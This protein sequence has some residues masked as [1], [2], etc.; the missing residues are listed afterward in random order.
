MKPHMFVALL[1]TSVLLI[2][3]PF[4]PH[5]APGTV[6]VSTFPDEKCLGLLSRT[7]S[8]NLAVTLTDCRSAPDWQILADG[9]IG[10]GGRRSPTYCLNVDTASY[11]PKNVSI[12]ECSGSTSVNQVWTW[13]GDGT[14]KLNSKDLCLTTTETG[15]GQLTI[16]G[17]S[18]IT[19]ALKS[20][21][22]GAT[23][24]FNT[25]YQVADQ[26]KPDFEPPYEQAHNTRIAKPYD[27]LKPGLRSEV[28]AQ[29][30][31]HSRLLLTDI[32]DRPFFDYF[33][34]QTFIGLIWPADSKHR[35]VADPSVP[36]GKQFREKNTTGDNC[37]CVPVVWETFRTVSAAL[38][39]PG[40]GAAAPTQPKRWNDSDTP[41]KRP[42]N[43]DLTS[44]G[45]SRTQLDEAF[46]SPLIDQNRKYVRYQL[47]LNEVLYEFVRRNKWYL[48]G[49]L[50]KSPTIAGLPPLSV[51]P[52][53][54]ADKHGKL[55]IQQQPQ[56]NT[57][58]KQPVNGNSI[59]I[60]AAWRIMIEEAE[61]PWQRV[62]DLSRYFVSEA[63]ISDPSG[64]M[65]SKVRKVGLV[66]LH[67]VVKTPQ[68]SQGIW[69]SFEHVDNLEAP[70][71]IRPSFNNGNGIFHPKGFSYQPPTISSNQ[72]LLPEQYRT[73]VEVSRIYKIPNTPVAGSKEFPSSKEFP[74]GLSTQGMNQKY[75]EILEGTVW[76]N[77]QL[78]I[79]Q[80][81]TDPASFYAKPFLYPRGFEDKPP[82]SQNVAVQQAYER[83]MATAS[84]AYPRWS[85]LPIPQVGALNTTMETY[86]QNP[87]NGQSLESTSC[88]GCHYGASDT[89]YFWA[90]KLRTWPQPYDQGRLNPFDSTLAKEPAN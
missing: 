80:W 90:L 79:T 30:K 71:G 3:L 63:N 9:R 17:C 51:K 64:R 28:P 5:A 41:Y 34:W 12:W 39:G 7:A 70:S 49:N 72:N 62:D 65:P 4:Q 55:E 57:V 6:T 89:D 26:N 27:L 2:G 59:T 37:N 78:V 42:F 8:N 61:Y 47:Q 87:G 22:A 53:L 75:Q 77:Y 23:R 83:A 67:V 82:A 50:P 81:P 18:S 73:P 19:W 54:L 36:T 38:P 32:E 10:L 13:N 29:L 86:F 48:K 40:A 1:T 45:K 15:A 76:K 56:T 74:Y 43:L 44:K 33:A 68:F 69:A 52:P 46:S 66:G 58:V 21:S 16:A 25:N 31:P 88:M 24:N 14:I 60:K 85:G 11:T 84:N 35:G 20:L